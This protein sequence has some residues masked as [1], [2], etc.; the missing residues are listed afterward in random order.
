[1]KFWNSGDLVNVGGI[2]L[3]TNFCDYRTRYLVILC[4]FRIFATPS[5][6]RD[7]V[8]IEPLRLPITRPGSLIG[9]WR[10]SYRYHCPGSRAVTSMSIS[11][12]GSIKLS[13]LELCRGSCCSGSYLPLINFR[14]SERW[15]A[16]NMYI[17]KI[18]AV[19]TTAAIHIAGY[20]Q[21]A[22]S[23][24]H[25]RDAYMF[26]LE[27]S[28]ALARKIQKSTRLIGISPVVF[29]LNHAPPPRSLSSY[30]EETSKTSTE[31]KGILNVCQSLEIVNHIKI[32]P[33]KS[34]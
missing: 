13:E 21:L 33:T 6:V 31:L 11:A 17:V 10:T 9:G 8:N 14:P 12:R 29:C 4:C 16:Q 28:I 15:H 24:F 34:P 7:V 18:R 22:M 27:V 19:K 23:M 2:L 1:M 3:A 20:G 26:A 5:V 25:A 32:L 30:N